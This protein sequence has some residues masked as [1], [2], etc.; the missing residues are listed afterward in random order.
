M[1]KTFVAINDPA[2]HLLRQLTRQTPLRPLLAADGAL[3]MEYTIRP[4]LLP[5]E[6]YALALFHD[7][8][9]LATGRQHRGGWAGPARER[10]ALL[11]RVNY[12]DAVHLDGRCCRDL[13]LKPRRTGP[14]MLAAELLAFGSGALR[15]R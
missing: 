6:Y 7:L 15:A 4:E 12:F 14:G 8:D 5:E 13:R 2:H 3:A 1:S 10:A 9:G 11:A